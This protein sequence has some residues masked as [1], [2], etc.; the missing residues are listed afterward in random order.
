MVAELVR[1]TVDT[2][3]KFSPDM[4]G[5]K[6]DVYIKL[7]KLFAIF[8]IANALDKSH[9]QKFSDVKISLKQNILMITTNTVEDITLEYGLFDDKANFFEEVYGIKPCIK[10]KRRFT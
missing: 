1:Y 10:Q 3:P 8:S 9:K 7:S 6:K 4:D 5:A 2:F